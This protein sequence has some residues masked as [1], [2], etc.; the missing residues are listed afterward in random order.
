MLGRMSIR[1]KL[2]FS[3]LGITVIF[4]ASCLLAMWQL[5][6]INTG[7]QNIVNGSVQ[8]SVRILY[9][10]S[11]L[12]AYR[13]A[14][15]EYILIGT[16]SLY[17]RAE[18]AKATV[19]QAVTLLAEG[20]AGTEAEAEF[21]SEFI[22]PWE[23]VVAEMEEAVLWMRAGSP[24]VAA[25]EFEQASHMVDNIIRT[26]NDRVVQVNTERSRE[27][28]EL[29]DGSIRTQRYL[30]VMTALSTLL[31]MFFMVRI[32]PLIARP[33]SALADASKRMAQG[34]L[35]ISALPV[36]SRD[37]VGQMTEAFNAMVRHMRSLISEVVSSSDR[38]V[39][40][41]EEMA[42]TAEEAASASQQIANVIQQV[43]AGTADQTSTV[44]QAAQSVEE[45]RR[46]ID[47][48][49]AGATEQAQQVHR[50]YEIVGQMRTAVENAAN[51]AGEIA[52]SA[53]ESIKNARAGGHVVDESVRSMQQISRTTAETA[54]KIEE[55]GNR[56]ARVGEI[57]GVISEIAD[58][59]NL[60]ALNA[61]IEAARAGEHGKGFAVV[62]DEV[63]KLAERS[64]QSANEIAELVKTIQLG[65][66]EAVSAMKVN[67][68]EVDKGLAL[69][70][71]AG[72]A[73]QNILTAFEGLNAE[74]Q[75]ITDGTEELRQSIEVV[76][77]EMDNIAT[78]AEENLTATEAMSGRSEQVV[79]AMES[80]SAV[81]EETAASAEEV[82][83]STEEATASNEEMSTSAQALADLAEQLKSAVARFK[84]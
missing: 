73:L 8:N 16:N 39:K 74:I 54:R 58:Q 49:A 47:Q 71:E 82:S 17:E 78:I 43:A 64:A 3:L 81:S 13:A 24:D 66:Q 2:A 46:A 55:L 32:P 9:L 20:L 51:N 5:G 75:A 26:I 33:V 83:A 35:T 21:E 61:A 30:T 52:R 14:V 15:A 44:T 80:I 11:T 41:S 69:S 76:A 23:I 6:D 60:L 10:N 45:L 28:D 29:I 22:V 31:A 57:V 34:D 67:T 40:S 12:E 48:I 72:Q 65:T 79:A 38:L 37:E 53:Q 56:S 70:N 63:R 50:T 59:T 1:T 27:Q 19:D 18:G 7:I 77:R 68:D 42:A 84:V 62:A 25:E 4:L 36:R